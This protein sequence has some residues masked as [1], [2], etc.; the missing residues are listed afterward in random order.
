MVDTDRITG[1]ARELGGK[2]QGAQ[3]TDV[4]G[5]SLGLILRRF[6]GRREQDQLIIKKVAP[7]QDARGVR[8]RR[9]PGEKENETKREAAGGKSFVIGHWSLVIGHLGVSGNPGI[10]GSQPM[11]NDE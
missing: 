3:D 10:E 9:N 5:R 7:H 8:H 2:V 4:L 11:T 6:V 1:A